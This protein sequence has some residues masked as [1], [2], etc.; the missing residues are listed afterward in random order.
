MSEQAIV[1]ARVGAMAPFVT[2]LDEI[3]A[4]CERLLETERLSPDLLTDP[5]ALFPLRQGL[6]FIDAAARSQGIEDL[7]LI[8]GRRTGIR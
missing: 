3:G 1:L 4:P 8:V 7:G 6:R 2:F 5:G